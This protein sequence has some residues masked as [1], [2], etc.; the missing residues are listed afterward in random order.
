MT[1]WIA[2]GLLALVTALVIAGALLRPRATEEA[3]GDEQLDLRIYRDQLAAVDRDL[4]RGTVGTDEADRLRTEIKRRILDADRRG[5]AAPGRAPRAL[6]FGVA[7]VVGVAVIVGSF[8]LYGRLGAPGYPDLPIGKRIAET[9]T[10][11]AE[12][13]TQAELEAKMPPAPAPEVTAEFAELMAKLRQAVAERPGDLQGVELLA[14]NEA[15]LGN[16]TA[17]HAAQSKAIALKGDAATAQDYTTLAALM[18]Q[19]AG[20]NVSPEADHALASAL[21]LDPTDL[22]AR[23]YA[24]LMYLQIGRPDVTFRYWEPLLAESPPEAPW[25]PIVRDRIETIAALAGIKYALPPMMSAGGPGPSAADMAAAADMSPEERQDFIRTMVGQLSARLM[26]QGGSPE[27]WARLI[28][29]QAT[30]GDT[31]A[32]AEAWAAAQ[33][34]YPDAARQAPIRAVAEQAGVAT[35]G[36]EGRGPTAPDGRGPTAED[37][38][39]AAGMAPQ[40]RAQMI[41]GMVAQLGERLATEGGP[42]EDWAKLVR[43]LGV[44]GNRDQASAIWEEAQTRFSDPAQ[45]DVIRQAAVAAGV[46]Q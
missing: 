30:L 10:L 36:P 25:L 6:S 29:S 4:A 7:S 22:V 38:Q 39:N 24:G 27:E 16:L 41:Q 42:P 46:A 23:Y 9:E 15:R 26:D 2:S 5:S 35:V 33:K 31:A 19:A 13:P 1:F 14:R 20:G 8:L 45:L 28:R 3:A 37:V 43:A 21:R 32:A 17:A 11:R 34:A 18:I 12:R 40:D 44:L